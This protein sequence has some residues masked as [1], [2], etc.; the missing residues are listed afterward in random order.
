[1]LRAARVRD[2][3]IRRTHAARARRADAASALRSRAL[4]ARDARRAHRRS[5]RR[6]A[7]APRAARG[8]GRVQGGDQGRRRALAGRDARAVHRA[9]ATRRSP[10]TTCTVARRSCSSPG[11]RLSGASAG[12]DDRVA[13]SAG[14]PRRGRARSRCGS[15]SA[16]PVTIVSA[17][18]RQVYRG[19][20]IGTAKP[21][22][23][24]RA[25]VPHRG[26]DVV[27]PTERYSAARV[28]GRR[29]TAGST[30]RA[31]VGRMPIVVG[32]TGLYLRAL[33]DGLF[34]EPP[35]DPIARRALERELDVAVDRRAAA[36]GRAR[37]IPRA[38]T[39][40]ERSCCAP[41]EI[42][43][44][45]GQRVSELHR[46]RAHAAPLAAAL[47]CGGSGSGAGRA[48]RA[49]GSTTCSTTGGQTRCS[50]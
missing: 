31:R 47:S 49:R 46:D 16:Q 11:T 41:I 26:I 38:R 21:T 27:D 9:C 42:A 32:G 25:R 18:S 34:E 29:P 22:A 24:E 28:G 8:D 39:S 15:P 36:L 14:R 12:A 37:S 35:L 48:H 10:R 50:A 1:M 6:R 20:D 5:R 3:G 23:D 40:V 45:T 30:R 33:F 43:L 13:S 17:D 44:L 19:F 4:P 7:R 2:R